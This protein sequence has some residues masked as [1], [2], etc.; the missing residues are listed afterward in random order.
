MFIALSSRLFLV[1]SR[2]F[3]ILKLL[4]L[5]FMM[6]LKK[7]LIQEKDFLEMVI[8]PLFDLQKYFV[9]V[10]FTNKFND[11]VYVKQAT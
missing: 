6:N 8:M 4:I 7:Y 11:V 9:I 3:K 5:V 10:W 1:L 2:I